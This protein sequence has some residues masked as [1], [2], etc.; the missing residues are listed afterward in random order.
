M[1]ALQFIIEDQER[2]VDRLN[3]LILAGSG[4]VKYGEFPMAFTGLHDLSLAY[5]LGQMI[6]RQ[7]VM[8]QQIATIC[9]RLANEPMAQAVAQEILGQAKAHLESMQE[10][11]APT[12]AADS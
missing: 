9:E 10:A 7:K 1:E 11:A 5:L 2:T 4:S 12:P 6:E 8:V 3:E